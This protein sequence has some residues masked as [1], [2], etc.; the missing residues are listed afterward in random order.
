[1]GKYLLDKLSP[2]A[3]YTLGLQLCMFDG[4][5]HASCCKSMRLLCFY[6][7]QSMLHDSLK[8]VLLHE[9]YCCYYCTE[10]AAA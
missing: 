4:W 1:M 7:M 8:R 10:G 5:S 3:C 6:A 9:C 2:V